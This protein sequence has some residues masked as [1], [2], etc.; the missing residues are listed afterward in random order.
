[1]REV[2][3]GR[4]FYVVELTYGI[5]FVDHTHKEKFSIDTFYAKTN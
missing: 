3:N 2:T 1:M 4:D 5:G